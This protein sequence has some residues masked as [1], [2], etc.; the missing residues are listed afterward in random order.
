MDLD[1]AP[2]KL[3]GIGVDPGGCCQLLVLPECRLWR[4]VRPDHPVE[5]KVAVV[6]GVVEVAAIRPPPAA[7]ARV[8]HLLDETVIPPLPDKAALQAGGRLDGGPILGQCP[9]AIAHGVRVLAHDQGMA[10]HAGLPVGH[11]R[12]DR[13]I[14]RCGDVADGLRPTPIEPNGALVVERPRSVIAAEPGGCGIV[15]GAIA[16]FVAERPEDD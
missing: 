14:H 10:L 15:V 6:W 5:T 1:P 12:R 2:P 3:R 16:R 13:R 11:D 8:R 7:P 4:A 9:V